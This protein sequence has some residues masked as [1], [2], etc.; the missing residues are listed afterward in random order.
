MYQ[1]TRARA[2]AQTVARAQRAQEFRTHHPQLVEWLSTSKLSFAQSLHQAFLRSGTLTVN[3]RDAAVKCMHDAQQRTQQTLASAA[4]IDVSRIV[5]AFDA[6]KAKGVKRPKMRLGTYVFS[7]APDNGANAGALYVK[8]TDDAQTYLG[9][10]TQGRF[11]ST[12]GDHVTNAKVDEIIALA[13]DP[14]NAAIAYGRRTG[15]CAICGR[16]LTNHASIEL[17]IGPI[18]AEK[19]GF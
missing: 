18:C 13:S 7:T 5:T 6:A 15:D 3:Q 10:I 16:E 12:R 4:A 9:K 8:E 14:M 1:T 17:G 19:F 2:A 11:V